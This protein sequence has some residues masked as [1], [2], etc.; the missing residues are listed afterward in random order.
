MIP[1]LIA[2]VEE[3]AAT[4]V[5]NN[6]QANS[7]IRKLR[8]ALLSLDKGQEIAAANKLMAFINQVEAFVAAGILTEPQARSLIDQAIAAIDDIVGG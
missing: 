3:L 1:A 5:L 7:L 4:G 2:D 6:G 8:S